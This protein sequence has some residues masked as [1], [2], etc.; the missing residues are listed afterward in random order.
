M[1]VKITLAQG[2]LLIAIKITSII[3]A[4]IMKRIIRMQRMTIYKS[5]R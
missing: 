5:Y 3:A 1:A 2:N 4:F